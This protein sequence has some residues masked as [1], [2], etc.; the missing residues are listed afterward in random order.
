MDA[1]GNSE[2]DKCKLKLWYERLGQAYFGSIKKLIASSGVEGVNQNDKRRGNQTCESCM[3]SNQSRETLRT[4]NS[5]S[6]ERCA[7]IHTDV[8]GPLNVP[9][10][11]IFRYFVSFI[12]EYS[13][14]MVVVPI[15]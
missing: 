9:S 10:S 15:V 1:S 5:R 8:C 2:T 3:K 12:D 13:G 4:N 7:V 11:S 14:Y 6:K